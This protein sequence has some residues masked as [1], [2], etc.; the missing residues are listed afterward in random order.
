MGGMGSGRGEGYWGPKPGGGGG[1]IGG[2]AGDKRKYPGSDDVWKPND[3]AGKV[4]KQPKL[5]KSPSEK[6]PAKV[7]GAT[8]DGSPW[9]PPLRRVTVARAA[10]DAMRH[11]CDAELPEGLLDEAEIHKISS[12]PDLTYLDAPAEEQG[13]GLKAAPARV[14]W[15]PPLPRMGT[16]RPGASIAPGVP[17]P[18]GAHRRVS[19]QSGDHRGR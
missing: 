17:I 3:T 2:H 11:A 12:V 14:M 8:K 10:I 16:P 15:A 6:A 9:H 13:G 1:S 4:G 5:P 18:P 19:K 7:A